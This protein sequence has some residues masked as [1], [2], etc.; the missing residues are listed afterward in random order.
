MAYVT[1]TG[2]SPSCLY[3]YTIGAKRGQRFADKWS[4]VSFSLTMSLCGKGICPFVIHLVKKKK[5]YTL[6]GMHL[7]E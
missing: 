1:L 3:A 7:E 4:R 6:S 2:F 5:S